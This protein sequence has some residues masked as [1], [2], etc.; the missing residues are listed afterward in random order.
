MKTLGNHRNNHRATIHPGSLMRPLSNRKPPD[1]RGVLLLIVLALLALFGMLGVAFVLLSGQAQRSAKSIE[2]VELVSERPDKLLREAA[3]QVFR[4]TN[5]PASVLGAHSLLEDIYGHESI[6][7]QV[8]DAQVAGEGGFPQL[9]EITTNLTP[10]QLARRGGCVLTITGVPSGTSGSTSQQQALVGQSTRIVG[11]LLGTSTIQVMAFPNGAIPPQGTS[12][13]INGVPFSGTGFGWT[14]VAIGGGA[15]LPKLP[16]ATNGAGGA[17]EDYDAP[18]FQNMLLAAQVKTGNT[19]QTLPSLHRPALVQYWMN[20]NGAATWLDLWANPNLRNLCRSI[21]FRPIGGYPTA[22]HPSFTG[23]NLNPNGFDPINGP[24]DVDNDGDGVPDSIW[25][26]LGFPVR[27]T[28]DGRLYKPLFAILCLDLDG[29]LNLN[30][31]G[32][33]VQCESN[34]LNKQ[35]TLPLSGQFAGT[36]PTPPTTYGQGFGPAEINLGY[37]LNNLT[38]Y[39][40]LLSGGQGYQGRYGYGTPPIPGF[41]ALEV[42]SANKWFS[43]GGNYWDFSSPNQAGAYGSPVDPFGA[44]I[45]GLDFA[46]RPLYGGVS[47]GA[48]YFG[49]GS[50]ING[51]PYQMNL[52]PDQARG[53]PNNTTAPDNPFSLAEL[54][55][56]LRPFDRDAPTLPQRLLKLSESTP[57]DLRSSVL[58]GKRHSVS[59]ESWDLPC[60]NIVTS[61]SLTD[62]ERDRLSDRR[63]KHITDLLRARGVP[64][65]AWADLLPPDLLAGLRMDIN[66]PFGNGRD[67]NGN[68]V[69][70]EPEPQESEQIA[71]SGRTVPLSYNEAGVY[72]VFSND[73]NGEPTTSLAAR[74]LMAR[75]LYVLAC[76]TVDRTSLAGHFG[77][78]YERA[79]RF[80]AQWA[81]NVVDFR[82]RDS[83]MT[84]FDYDPDFADPN[85]DITDGWMPPG[86]PLHR[87][88]GCERPELL[89]T[90][91]L[92]FHDRR[93][94]DTAEDPTGKD[95]QDP[96]DPDDDFDQKRKPQGSLFVELFNPWSAR[97]PRTG[98]LYTGPNDGVD[99]TRLSAA[100]NSPVWRL[101]IVDASEA[102]KD[103]DAPNPSNRPNIERAVYFCGQQGV[104]LPNDSTHNYRPTESYAGKVAPVLPGRYVV[105]GPGEPE[106]GGPAATY[107]GYK[108][109][110]TQ[111][112]NQTR[113]IVL[114][115]NS[116]PSLNQIQIF[117]VGTPPQDDLAGLVG[118]SIQ[119]ATAIV[120]NSPHRLSISEPDG[121]YP[122]HTSADGKT[123]DPPFDEPLD[124]QGPL[125]DK[126]RRTD[127]HRNVKVLHLQRLA[128]PLLPYDAHDNPYRT[129]DSMSVDLTCFNGITSSPPDPRDDGDEA[130]TKFY[131]R[132]RGENNDTAQPNNLWRREPYNEETKPN[133]NLSDATGHHFNNVLHHTLGYLNFPFGQPSTVPG[134]IGDPQ[135]PFPWLTWNN[136][137]YVSQLEVL[138]VPW[139]RSSQLLQYFNLAQAGNP[140]E[141]P[142][143]PFPHLLNLF[144]SGA[145]E[146]LDE[147]LHRV[148]EFL[149]VPSP[150]VG[151]EIWANPTAAA[152]S[153][154][155]AFR[156]PFNRISTYREPGRIN[157]NT[158][159]DPD[160]FKGLMND[161]PGMNTD[162]FWKKFVRSRRG[163]GSEDGNILSSDPAWPTEFGRPFRS[164]GGRR[165]SPNELRPEREIDCTLLRADPEDQTKPLFHYESLAQVDNTD[166]NPYFRYQGLQRLA[167]LVTTRSNVYAVWITVG[168]FEVEPARQGYDP[169][170]YPDGYQLGRELG[171]DTGEIERHR[172]FFIFDRSIPVGFVRGQDLNVEKAILVDRFIE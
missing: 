15:L 68:G 81:V 55:R 105:I 6:S 148:L 126:I 104:N 90:E 107:I 65:S 52:G 133:G 33:L 26:D 14:G 50:L 39:Q 98:D 150:F 25:V 63:V 53:L 1:R 130:N 62:V 86:D 8:V 152:N 37:L 100:G 18:D 137:P 103:P 77:G 162:N 153:S 3:M 165:L 47:S 170:I 161:F 29:R 70:D 74:Q 41:A 31:H 92:A 109:N 84:P 27:A 134:Y 56:I 132:E 16:F 143:V 9:L 35:Y 38:V 4:G 51:L 127:T 66:R 32:N 89:I 154:G 139:V 34:Y 116:D 138:L 44:G 59:T 17:N 12:F 54:E 149:R 108:L 67:D 45:V 87:V 60:P 71:L 64:E 151:T 146:N 160:V 140:Y 131:T 42:L 80:L 23:S 46:G 115:P 57:G 118:S 141:A 117:N 75:Y 135:Q 88:W 91:T 30:A 171:I 167:N 7:G 119:P 112:D 10:E 136:R 43:Y 36:P 163:Y 49:Y 158:I 93:T 20:K 122:N 145:G 164:F 102:A 69:V 5:N 40:Q 120:V 21:M 113:R 129:I 156:P 144:L 13:I 19:V 24:W 11:G 142:G 2:R 124:Q 121:G 169:L 159:Y 128:N 83:I 48:I 155:H 147:E 106:D 73:P 99:L 79:A 78:D 125:A 58:I 61:T 97:E 96:N 168:Y 72:K 22:D 157:L 111:G 28:S 123:Y 114:N 82:D 94:E 166:R 101:I 172:A 95:T 76:L 110:A 85:A